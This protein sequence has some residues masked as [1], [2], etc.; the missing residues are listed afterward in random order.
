L[1]SN[2]VSDQIKSLFGDSNLVIGYMAI[3]GILCLGID[4]VTVMRV[5]SGRRLTA[6]VASIS[7]MPFILMDGTITNN[8]WWHLQAIASI[9][10]DDLHK[11]S[12]TKLFKAIFLYF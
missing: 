5:S 6:R 9:M 10:A 4:A 1:T 2:Q 11:P 7:S 12:L 3:V 8:Q